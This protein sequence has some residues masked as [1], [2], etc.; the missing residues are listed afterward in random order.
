MNAYTM[1]NLA[2]DA[3]ISVHI[4]RD[5]V[6]RGLVFPAVRTESGYGIFDAQ[7]LQRLRF[8]R[9]AFEAGIPLGT[10]VR[11]CRALDA[12]DAARANEQAEGLRRDL[13]GRRHALR[14]VEAQLS[15]LVPSRREARAHLEVSP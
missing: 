9:A 12:G 14:D 6:L 10:L 7:A 13:M 11:L 8:V 2:H 4:V 3:G 5:Y 1:T 15:R